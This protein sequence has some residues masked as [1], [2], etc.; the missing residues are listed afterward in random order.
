MVKMNSKKFI[1]LAFPFFL[2][3]R[4]LLHSEEKKEV[5]WKPQISVYEPPPVE[6]TTSTV[7]RNVDPQIIQKLIDLLEEENLGKLESGTENPSINE[8][9][10]FVTPEGFELKN[11]YTRLG[12]ALSEALGWEEIKHV[13]VI[14]EQNLKQRLTTVARWDHT[15]NVRGIALMALASLKD[16][17]DLVYFKEA[18]WSRNIGIRFAAIEALKNWGISEAV[19]VLQEVAAK[20]ESYFLRVV[21]QNALFRLGDLSAVEML[22]TNLESKDWF[23]RALSARFLG[24]AGNVE[25]YDLVLNRISQ[26]QS[27]GMNEFTVAELSIAALKLFP[28]KIEKDRL[29]R[30]KKELEKKRKKGVAV[31]AGGI[32]KEVKPRKSAL[33]ELEPLVVTAPRLKIPPSELVD[34]RINYQLLK[35][36]QEKEDLRVTQEQIDQSVSYKDLNELDTPS[37]IRLKARYTVLGFLLTEGLAGT[38]DFQLVDQLVRIARGGKNPDV[39]SFALIAL[40]YSRD[41][42]HLGLFQQ[43]LRSEQSADRFAAIEALQIWNYEDAVSILIGVTKLDPSPIIKVYA[44]EAVLRM[45]NLIGKDFLIRSLDDPDWVARAMAMRSLGELGGGEDYNKL[46]SYLGSQQKSIVQ[47]EMC[48]SLLRLYAKKIEK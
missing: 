3:V 27:F 13:R 33:F 42:N 10:S 47:A 25:D 9:N 41:R 39:R 1:F 17:N 16:K 12:V 2:S 5:S 31:P 11:R 38:T 15:P 26:E 34:S 37:G 40:A 4:C 23:V 36:I 22:R 29:E 20:D 48:S 19:P 28:L 6:I 24:E 32:K 14:S 21:A 35:M 46:L 8:I 45:G 30:E 44:A 7:F 18:L 43:A